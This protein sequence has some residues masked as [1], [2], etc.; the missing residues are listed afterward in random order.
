MAE[1]QPQTIN[2][3]VHNALIHELVQQRD[4]ALAKCVNLG[5]E[6]TMLKTFIKEHNEKADAIAEEEVKASKPTKASNT[7]K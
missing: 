4:E 7:A 5:A 1:N 2:V 6:V 3:N